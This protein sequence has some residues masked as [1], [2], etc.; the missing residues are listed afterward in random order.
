VK[1]LSLIAMS[2]LLSLFVLAGCD[3]STQ[4]A[5][6]GPT[7]ADALAIQARESAEAKLRGNLNS[8][9]TFHDVRTFQQGVPG[10]VAVCGQV[11][12][13]GG[14]QPVQFVSLV[15]RQPDGSLAV[16]QHVATD[17]VSATRVYV[18]TGTRCVAQASRD[19]APRRGAPPPLPVIPATLGTLTPASPPAVQRMEAEAKAAASPGGVTLRQPGN[20]RQSPQGGAAVVRV[21]PRGTSLQVFAEA[22][23]GWLQVG[24]TEAEGWLHSSLVTRNA[25]APSPLADAR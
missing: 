10:E 20:L 23:G 6:A 1:T 8:N 17:N 16:E 2:G 24:A 7:P 14:T 25:A 19:A 11:A 15:T 21:V 22:A 12:M 3:D 13:T 5:D 18:E 4:K 9:L